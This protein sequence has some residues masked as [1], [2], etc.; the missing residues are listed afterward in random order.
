MT[1]NITNT[2]GQA[3]AGKITLPNGEVETPVF[4]PVGT[5]GTVKAIKTGNIEEIG[6]RIILANTYHL[7]L[8]PGCDVL[9]NFR[10][11]HDFM[12]WQYPIL[13]D[14]GGFQIMSLSKLTKIE[15]E[16]VWFSSHI[17]GKK[18]FFT[19]KD[20]MDVQNSINSDIHM[21]LDQCIKFESAKDS[22]RDAMNLSL[23]WAE[24]S[25]KHFIKKPKRKLFGIVQGGVDQKL[26]EY[27]A[28][29]TVKLAFDGYAI[30]GLAVGEGHDL[31]IRTLD[32]TVP[33][34]P[35]D[36][37]RY[38]M[39]VG[40]P[41]DIVES[42]RRGVDMFDCVMPTRAG[43]HGLAY[44]KN[45]KINLRNS[46]YSNDIRP[47]DVDIDNP[48]VKN[49]SRAYL[50]HLFKSREILGAMILSE[51]NLLYYKTLINQLREAILNGNFDTQVSLIY[52]KWN[53]KEN[54]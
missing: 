3:R 31:M 16:G 33:Y 25:K 8:R 37:P 49:Y 1:Y 42:I 34:L 13:T 29:N 26:R 15:D 5:Q 53:K 23:R 41:Q 39:G 30:G 4:M 51:I 27:S 17:D 9:E 47:I 2:D 14:S 36:K 6:Y 12:N 19:P 32:F 7:F 40:T 46:K 54:I 11:L 38:L 18:F 50:H 21:V 20:S 43:R 24:L 52:E 44:T 10:G 28:I 48:I 22:V 45:G 35:Q